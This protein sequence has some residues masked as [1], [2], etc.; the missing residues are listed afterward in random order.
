MAE[1]TY[2]TIFLCRSRGS[3]LGVSYLRDLAATTAK[4]RSKSNPYCG[5]HS[6]A[7]WALHNAKGDDNLHA[8]PL[9]KA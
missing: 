9:Q 5:I 4:G 1:D 7:L 8:E 3:S 2:F 6:N